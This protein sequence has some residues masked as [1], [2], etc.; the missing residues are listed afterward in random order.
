[1]KYLDIITGGHPNSL[2]DLIH[3]QEGVKESLEA[4]IKGL[5]V[6]AS[7][8]PQNCILWGLDEDFVGGN[9]IIKEGAVLL[10]GEICIFPEHNLGNAVLPPSY[11][12][13]ISRAT[14]YHVDDP[15][16]Y[17]TS[18][19]HSPHVIVTGTAA[20]TNAA[21]QPDQM[22]YNV[23]TTP[24]LAGLIRTNVLNIDDWHTVGATNEPPFAANYSATFIKF[25]KSVSDNVLI[26]VNALDMSHW[27]TLLSLPDIHLS[28]EE[29]FTLPSGY[30]PSFTTYL[31]APIN[32]NSFP[33]EMLG[34][35]IETNGKVYIG[36]PASPPTNAGTGS[37]N[38][39]FFNLNT[40][41]NAI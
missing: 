41:F 7:N 19:S 20:W 37:F 1:M 13:V 24:R 12:I 10:S 6:D 8:A 2:N 16:I 40:M 28:T 5:A 17:A 29:V 26:A 11:N 27:A 9:R 30:R 21:V 14:S 3:L 23:H 32:L 35:R 33:Q 39:K 38:N 34:L 15:V 18:V 31:M 4:W 36:V 22:I 25:K